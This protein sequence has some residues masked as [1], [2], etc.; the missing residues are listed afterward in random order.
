MKPPTKE[1]VIHPTKTGAVFLVFIA[2]GRLFGFYYHPLKIGALVNGIIFLE[3]RLWI[4]QTLSRSENCRAEA[5][6]TDYL[7]RGGANPKV[8]QK[9]RIS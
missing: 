4:H 8:A 5:R 1:I 3:E 2:P 7:P 9:C 6:M